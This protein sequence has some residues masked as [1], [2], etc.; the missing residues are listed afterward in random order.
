MC[1]VAVKFEGEGNDQVN[2]NLAGM[3]NSGK[4][5]FRTDSG[6]E[7]FW[8]GLGSDAVCMYPC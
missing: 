2:G 8:F 5:S 4:L 6:N 3:I 1:R 7:C